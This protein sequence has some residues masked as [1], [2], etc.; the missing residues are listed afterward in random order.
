MKTHS[1]IFLYYFD[2]LY[3]SN[4]T[5]PFDEKINVTKVRFFFDVFDSRFISHEFIVIH[6]IEEIKVIRILSRLFVVIIIIVMR[7]ID[8]I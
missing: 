6:K 2:I 1:Q 5:G 4:I 7:A 8:R 3:R